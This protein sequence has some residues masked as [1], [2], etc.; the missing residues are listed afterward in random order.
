MCLCSAVEHDSTSAIF[1]K[2]PDQ[3]AEAVVVPERELSIV[4]PRQPQDW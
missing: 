2:K 4:D 1:V 3:V